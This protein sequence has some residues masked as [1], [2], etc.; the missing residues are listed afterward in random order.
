MP[1]W[2]RRGRGGLCRPLKSG[3]HARFFFLWGSRGVFFFL[4]PSAFSPANRAPLPS[5]HQHMRAMRLLLRG[6][7]A[8]TS[9]PGGTHASRSLSVRSAS[10]SPSRASTA[11]LPAASSSSWRTTFGPQD[12]IGTDGALVT[13]PDGPT[14]RLTT[15]GGGLV[16]GRRAREAEAGRVGSERAF[17]FQRARGAPPR[18]A[19]PPSPALHPP[20]ASPSHSHAAAQR[21]L[22]SFPSTPGP[23]LRL[24][25]RGRRV[26]RP[27]RPAA[28]TRGPGLPRRRCVL[29][30]PP[31]RSDGGGR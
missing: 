21:M 19:G 14:H 2:V 18:P 24:R 5:P 10:S 7:P 8:S 31:A 11:A 28:V 20:H 3:A 17:F 6:T 15:P 25:H 22:R 1:V 16:R 13:D 26:R 4:S 9:L 29:R 30:L 12:R 27:A 23:G